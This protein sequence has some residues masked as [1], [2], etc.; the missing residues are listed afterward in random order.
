MDAYMHQDW[1]VE[2]ATDLEALDGFRNGFAETDRISLELLAELEGALAIPE[3]ELF[4]LVAPLCGYYFGEDAHAWLERLRTHLV[5]QMAHQPA[6]TDQPS[7][8]EHPQG[9][10]P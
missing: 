3:P 2:F 4:S 5:A 7:I 8:S 1:D 10:E 9:N 6:I